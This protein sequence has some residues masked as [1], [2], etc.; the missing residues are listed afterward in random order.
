MLAYLFLGAMVVLGH[1]FIFQKL[2]G[3]PVSESSYS[4]RETRISSQTLISAASNAV[5][6]IVQLLF[7]SAVGIAFSQHFWQV[8][9]P[10]KTGAEQ[11]LL[12]EEATPPQHMQWNNIEDIDVLLAEA[13]GN[14]FLPFFLWKR[15][16]M[17]GLALVV[18]IITGM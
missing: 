18:S 4:F 12:K 15:V 10:K 16:K 6:Q 7:G 14:R 3:T 9:A 1:H 5:S 8:V 17:S 13:S 11:H 2:S